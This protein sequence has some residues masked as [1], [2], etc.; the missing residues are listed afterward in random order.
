MLL[1]HQLFE[2]TEHISNLVF[3]F[4]RSEVLVNDLTE[5][6]HQK[7]NLDT[8]LGI[9]C[10]K[11]E[12]HLSR[13]KADILESYVSEMAGIITQLSQQAESAYNSTVSNENTEKS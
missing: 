7:I 2:I 5:Q 10:A 6:L 4:D 11:Q 3:L 13:V 8:P 1:K 9:A 12:R